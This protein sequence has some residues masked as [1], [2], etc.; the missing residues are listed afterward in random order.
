MVR[1]L[2]LNVPRILTRSLRR[3]APRNCTP[4]V[5]VRT[6]HFWVVS[7][8]VA[9]PILPDD[10][11]LVV[12][13]W[14]GGH[15]ETRS[16]A[17]GADP[18]RASTPHRELRGRSAESLNWVDTHHGLEQAAVPAWLSVPVAANNAI[19]ICRGANGRA[20]SSPPI[21][22]WNGLPAATDPLGNSFR[23]KP[24]KSMSELLDMLALVG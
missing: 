12:L 20:G 13:D 10:A 24:R 19:W 3:M 8:T 5:L 17:A 18:H 2:P 6:P 4:A 9:S 21:T 14:H 11:C 16:T 15:G 23:M 1:H 22:P 7:V